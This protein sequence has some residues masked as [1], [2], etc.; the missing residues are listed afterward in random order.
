MS[1]GQHFNFKSA[2]FTLIEVVISLAIFGIL[3]TLGYSTLSSILSAKTTLD[4]TRDLRAISDAVIGR[5]SREL[6]L[7]VAGVGVIPEPENLDKPN[8]SKVNLIGEQDEIG[9]NNGASSIQFLALEGGQYLP[10]GGTHAG[11]VQISYKVAKNPDFQPGGNLPETYLLIRQELP[12]LRPFK[13][14]YEKAMNFP[15][16]DNL[17]SLKFWYFEDETYSW[18]RT[19]GTEKH[20]GLPRMVKFELQ[21]QSPK[22]QLE[23]YSSTVPHRAKP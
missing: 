20:L 17:R 13:K 15:V 2:G 18:V 1:T 10:D 12:Y 3:M 19:W 5:L 23:T 4:D 11:I 7:A 21:L 8:S 14:A 9:D 22:G 16:V 6:Q